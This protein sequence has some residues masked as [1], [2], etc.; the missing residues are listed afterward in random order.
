MRSLSAL[1]Q[2]CNVPSPSSLSLT[3]PSFSLLFFLFSLSPSSLL[4]H[5]PSLPSF[6]LSSQSFGPD[7]DSII[8]LNLPSG[9]HVPK[10]VLSV[11]A[12]VPVSVC[13]SMQWY[14][15]VCRNITRLLSLNRTVPVHGEGLSLLLSLLHLPQ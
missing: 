6:F 5:T 8:T 15:R 12:T 7:T 9:K 4:S 3:P 13:K 10:L 2:P 1:S 11:A 14:E